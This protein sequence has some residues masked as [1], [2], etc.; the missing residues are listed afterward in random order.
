MNKSKPI[1]LLLA[2]GAL[3]SMILLNACN[4]KVVFERNEK[5]DPQGWHYL[6]KVDFEFES[7]DTSALY[8]VYL[9]VRNN[10]EYPYRNFIVFFQTHFPDGRIFTDTIEANLAMPSGEWTGEGFGNIKSN[11]FHFRRNVWF[12]VEGKYKFFIQHAMR[13]EYLPGITHIGIRIEEK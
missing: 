5:T 11:S 2:L 1:V 10:R 6:K 12:P 9:N 7:Q 13:N 4:D 3:V 8:N